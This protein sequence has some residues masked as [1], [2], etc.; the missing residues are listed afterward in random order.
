MR[1]TLRESGDIIGLLALSEL[2]EEESRE[3][4][5]T[6]FREIDVDAAGFPTEPLKGQWI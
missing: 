4:V 2:E 6:L 3:A 1:L 5:E